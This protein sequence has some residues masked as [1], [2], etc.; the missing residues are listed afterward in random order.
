MVYTYDTPDGVAVQSPPIVA[1]LQALFE[2]L[3]DADLL[4]HL[5]GPTRR[6]PKGHPVQ[7]LW[8]CLIVKHYLAIPSTAA[9][10]RTLE[11]N[12][13]IASACGIDSPDTIPHESTFSR[14]FARLANRKYLHLVKNVSRE[15]V[16]QCYAGLPAF[17]ERV[18]L[19]STTLKAWSNGGRAKKA[20]SEAGWSVKKGTQGVKEYTYG[21][22]LHLLVDCESELPIAANV[23]PGNVHD[24]KRATNVLSEARFTYMRFNPK[25]LLADQAYSGKE[26]SHTVKYQYSATPIIQVNKAHKRLA[27]KLTATQNTSEW[28]ALYKQRQAVE[29]VNS[30][31]K[32]QRSLNH[33]TT[34]GLRKV[35]VHCYLSLIAMQ[36][37]AM[38]SK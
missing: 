26:L 37:S 28:K 18:A 25:Y 21:W 7:T 15:L 38:A 13:Y 8:R 22:K 35:T 31:L 30:R 23:S 34:R 29:R 12:P 11:Q 5:E 2:R 32:G 27:A 24:S 14:F 36:V 33:I 9:M 10:I 16:R 17:G 3:P 6:G 19:D 1:E 4:A 20:D